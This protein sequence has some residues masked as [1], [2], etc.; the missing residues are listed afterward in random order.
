[1]TITPNNVSIRLLRHG[2]AELFYRIRAQGIRE[3]PSSF[4][5]S[6]DDFL[7]KPIASWAFQIENGLKT[8]R[9]F[10]FGAF[11]KEEELVGTLAL[12]RGTGSHV[13][14][15]GEIW[16]VYVTPRSR[17]QGVGTLLL[18]FCIK[19]AQTVIPGGQLRLWVSTTNERAIALY[20]GAGFITCGKVE[21][22]IRVGMSYFD[23]LLMVHQL[24]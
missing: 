21:R 17:G 13:S 2:D 4:S 15:I 8:Q 12:T 20:S 5:E 3:I 7:A 11:T 6:I 24:V 19:T 16:S 23:D 18:Q 9:E 10:F 22:A 14:H 1:M